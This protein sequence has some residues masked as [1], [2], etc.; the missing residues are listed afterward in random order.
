M[1]SICE[2]EVKEYFEVNL[3]CVFLVLVEAGTA[4]AA[5]RGRFFFTGLTMSKMEQMKLA[6]KPW[7]WVVENMLKY[8]SAAG[9][10]FLIYE[11]IYELTIKFSKYD[12]K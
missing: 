6:S 5:L 7:M 10:S 2:S 3:F 8:R 1:H 4:Q 12:T 9:Y 11:L